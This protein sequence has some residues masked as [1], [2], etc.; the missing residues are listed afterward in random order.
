MR[1]VFLL[2]MV[3]LAAAGTIF[4]VDPQSDSL[5]VNLT[6]KDEFSIKFVDKAFNSSSGDLAGIAKLGSVTMFAE[7][8]GNIYVAVQTNTLQGGIKI[9]LFGTGL[10]RY[11][12]SLEDD[13]PGFT[14]EVIPLLVTIDNNSEDN[15]VFND[16]V[17]IK[18]QKGTKSIELADKAAESDSS[19]RK[20]S[21]KIDLDA[22]T[23]N[24]T[25]GN[26][27]A[28]LTAVVSSI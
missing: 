2:L 6:V 14:T 8:E 7:P 20:I 13:L 12:E 16:T 1:K 22:D 27:V 23:S 11:T 9:E 15:T 25:A 19:I 26:Y 24:H 3:L 5:T 21:W 10:T 18:D 17:S 4:A 28:Y